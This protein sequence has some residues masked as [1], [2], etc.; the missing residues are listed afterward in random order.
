MGVIKLAATILFFEFMNDHIAD[1][2]EIE[3][4]VKVHW[5]KVEVAA[6]SLAAT[7]RNLERR[8]CR[9][10]GRGRRRFGLV[11]AHVAARIECRAKAL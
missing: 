7:I 6:E 8:Q 2:F 10:R 9:S 3:D 4:V 5:W 11:G 1:Q